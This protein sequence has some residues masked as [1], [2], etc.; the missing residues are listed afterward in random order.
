MIALIGARGYP[1]LAL[2]I[3]LARSLQAITS[4]DTIDR[5][6]MHGTID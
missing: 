6:N 3:L 2:Q 4:E 5:Q 1:V